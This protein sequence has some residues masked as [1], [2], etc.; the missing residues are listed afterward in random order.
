M[1]QESERER[2]IRKGVQDL[3]DEDEV[4]LI[5]REGSGAVTVRQM[6]EE[7]VAGL[8]SPLRGTH[9]EL[10]GQITSASEQIGSASSCLLMLVFL[11]L[12]AGICG[13][14]G[15][16]LFLDHIPEGMARSAVSALASWWGYAL[17]VIATMMIWSKLDD[18]LEWRSY[19]KHRD[20]ILYAADSASIRPEPLMAFLQGDQAAEKLLAYLKKDRNLEYYDT[21]ALL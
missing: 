9:P 12:A 11:G 18:Y 6:D 19:K 13:A 1:S 7:G 5:Q 15:T 17:V 14:L 21:T 20:R 4:F 16:G 2:F 3:L 8:I 10:Y